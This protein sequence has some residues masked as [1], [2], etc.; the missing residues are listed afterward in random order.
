MNFPKGREFQGEIHARIVELEKQR[1]PLAE[2]L[3]PIDE[4]LVRLR[5]YEQIVKT[6]VDGGDPRDRVVSH[7][8][9]SPNGDLSTPTIKRREVIKE[10]L[11]EASLPL[12]TSQI[13]DKLRAKGDPSKSDDKSFWRTIDA[14]LRRGAKPP[15]NCFHRVGKAIWALGPTAKK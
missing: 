13:C 11:S 12:T 2:Q 3:K 8:A 4:E 5:H 1:K 7:S 10:I 15:G 14:V 9:S 6:I